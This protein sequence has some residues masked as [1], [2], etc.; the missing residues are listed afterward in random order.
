MSDNVNLL[1]EQMNKNT[2]RKTR[3]G[4]VQN[5]GVRVKAAEQEIVNNDKSL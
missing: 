1:I 2:L 4:L 5:D 3:L